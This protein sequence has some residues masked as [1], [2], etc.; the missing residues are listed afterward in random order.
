MGAGVVSFSNRVSG[1]AA[2]GNC[3]ATCSALLA[4]SGGGGGGVGRKSTCSTEIFQTS[5]RKFLILD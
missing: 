2:G 5:R 3:G 4:A 1:M